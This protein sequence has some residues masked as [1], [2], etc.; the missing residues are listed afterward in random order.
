MSTLACSNRFSRRRFLASAGVCLGALSV[1]WGAYARLTSGLVLET[2]RIE[3]QNLYGEAAQRRLD[4]WEALLE[5]GGVWPLEKQLQEVNAFFNQL[6]FLNDGDQW[7]S[8][9]YWA[10]PLEFLGN[11]AGDCEEF[12]IAKYVSLVYLGVPVSQ[13]RITYVKALRLNQAHMVLTWAERSGAEPV[14]LDN[15][16]S[17]IQP[18]SQRQDLQP[19]YSFNAESLYLSNPGSE[20]RVSDASRVGSWQQLRARM[21]REIRL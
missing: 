2:A 17:E 9:D 11:G 19:V 15:L 12:A 3:Y 20:Q 21:A 4:A 8:R 18:A 7:G 13:L 1:G 5:T 6:R 14:V 10:T 16:I